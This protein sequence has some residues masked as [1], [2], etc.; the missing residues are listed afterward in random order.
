MLF[1]P[2]RRQGKIFIC[3]QRIDDRVQ[4]SIRDTGTGMPPQVKA[5]IFEPFFTTKDVGKG[6]GLGLSIS[7]SIIQKHHGSIEV[8]TEPGQGTEFI[9]RLPLKQDKIQTETQAINAH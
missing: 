5:R 1:R 9:I 6:T 7:H 2:F 8:E 3:T 4:I